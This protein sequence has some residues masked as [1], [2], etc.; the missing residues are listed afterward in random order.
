MGEKKPDLER[1]TFDRGLARPSLKEGLIPPDTGLFLRIED[2][3]G[4]GRVFALSAGGVYLIGR[5]GADIAL[6]DEKVSR[7]HAE[8]GLFGP[9]AFVVRDLASTNGT[10]LN[11]HRIDER[12]KLK[13]WD[14]IRV[15]DT[16]LR[17]SIVEGAVP[18]S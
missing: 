9:G 7:K 14:L 12:A 1:T 11:G 17:F 5:S 18:V 15:G 4:A 2:G 6:E 3:P 13:H 16:H 10:R 8:I